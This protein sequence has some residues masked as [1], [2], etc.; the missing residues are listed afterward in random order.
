[1]SKSTIN[2]RVV[3]VA[4]WKLGTYGGFHSH[5]G[6]P[7]IAGWFISLKIIRIEMDDLGVALFKKKHICGISWF[8]Y[9][10]NM[11]L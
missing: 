6:T 3:L 9:K 7:F 8:I 11:K 2:Q 4:W 1:M 10:G 5:G